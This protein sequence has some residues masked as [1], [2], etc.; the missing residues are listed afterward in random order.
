[1]NSGISYHVDATN[2]A[3]RRLGVKIEIDGPFNE[4][5]LELRFPRWVPGSYFIREPIQHM[6][7]LEA[8]CDNKEIQIKRIDVDGARITGI[9]NASKIVITYKLLAAEMTCRANH[10]DETHVHIMPPYTWMMP[11]RGIE[12]SRLEQSHKVTLDAP[13]GWQTA[14]QLAGKEGEWF[15]EGRDEFLDAIM[16]SN[17]NPII[18]FDVMGTTQYLK[19]WD[20]GGLPIPK[21]GLDRFIEAMKLVIE[22][23]FALF[24]IPEWKDYWTVLH[25][26]ESGRGG[27][28]HLRS[29]TSMMPRKCLQEGNEEQWRDLVSLFSHEFLH[30]W[31]VKQ[32]RPKNFLDYELQ[33][34]VHSDLLWWFEGLTSWLGDILCLR[35]GAWSEEDWRKDW[36]RKMK[37]HTDRNGMHNES[38]Q[39]SS[40]DAW[41][42]LY[43]PNSYSREVQISYYLEGEMAIFCLDVEL[44]KRSKGK[45]GMDDVMATLYHNHR[46]NSENP[47]I[48]HADIKKALVNT[49]GGRRL[50]TML[51]SLVGERKV[52]DVISAMKVLGL[53]MVPDKKEKGAWV[54]LNLT[55]N[56]NCVKVRTHFTG[57]PCRE[58]IH[59]GDEIIAVDGLRVKS[60]SD[61]SA[62]VHGNANVETTFT[63]A[64]EGVLHDVK[65]TPVPNPNHLTKVE[66]KGNKLWHAIKATMR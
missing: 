11:T 6:S 45:H 55:S 20:S 34:E 21:K 41:I 56:A 22:E 13:K 29:Q 48:T 62:A 8:T 53:E 24:G 51:D 57:S 10:L 65:I 32:L 59:T 26:T 43:R 64:R 7:N 17:A 36:T 16:E 38:L 39:E 49:P 52:P 35:S 46:L 50:G 5:I 2:G 14:T 12:K 30:Q 42:H 18:S 4:N 31:N 47:G 66:G 58:M 60:A 33:K 54:G 63:I 37:R 40:H 19:L 61:I 9:S 15:A 3:S 23:H 25:L 1:M 27:L 28:E 44:R